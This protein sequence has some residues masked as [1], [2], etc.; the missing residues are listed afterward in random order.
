MAIG[1]HGKGTCPP[2]SERTVAGY[3]Y[4]TQNV[5][6]AFPPYLPRNRHDKSEVEAT[7]Q[8]RRLADHRFFLF[9]SLLLHQ[10]D[11]AGQDRPRRPPWMPSNFVPSSLTCDTS[12]VHIYCSAC[13]IEL[14]N[15]IMPCP[16]AVLSL[17]SSTLLVELEAKTGPICECDPPSDVVSRCRVCKVTCCTRNDTGMRAAHC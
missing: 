10:D 12:Q 7:T 17:P 14:K 16:D 13:T 9:P 11:Q 3:L 5:S 2:K 4:P 6:L 15:F 1:K 8:G